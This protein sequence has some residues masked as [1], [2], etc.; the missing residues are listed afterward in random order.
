MYRFGDMFQPGTLT[1]MSIRLL[2]ALVLQTRTI[3]TAID[4]LE[5]FIWVLCWAVFEICLKHRKLNPFEQL[6]RDDLHRPSDIARMI[7]EK[8]VYGFSL[9]QTNF[10]FGQSLTSITPLV[11]KWCTLAATYRERV[12]CLLSGSNASSDIHQTLNVLCKE[13]FREYLDEGFRALDALEC[14]AIKW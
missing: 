5:S 10:P 3:V 4:D 6:F 8:T 1:F 11:E 14:K 2:G 12:T 13:A 7:K 9:Q